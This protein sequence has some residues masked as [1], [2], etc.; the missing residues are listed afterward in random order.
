M[1]DTIVVGAQDFE[2]LKVNKL[3]LRTDIN[4]ETGET[5]EKY[6]YNCKTLNLTIDNGG[7]RL[8]FSL[9]K[10]Y[11]LQDNFYPLGVNSFEVA[12]PSL[13]RSLQD[14]GV[15]ADIDT[16]KVLRLDLFKN[17]ETSKTFNSYADVLRT[18]DLKRTHRREYSEGFLTSNTLR[19]LCFYNKVRELTESLGSNYVKGVYNFNSEN[20]IRGELRFLRHQEVMKNG[21][22]YLKE[23]P[24]KWT[25]LKETY[26]NY[27]SDVFKYELPGGDVELKAEVLKALISFAMNSLREQGR[28]A[29]K[30]FGFYPYSFVNR[31]ELLN[32][33][34]E[35]YSKKQVYNILADIERHK[36]KYG[37]IYKTLEYRRLYSELKEKFINN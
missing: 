7:C 15:I 31:D 10:L 37:E 6:F 18:L 26:S 14:I 9:P 17:V 36:K 33:L 3:I 35:L 16:M 2:I 12:I 11:G 8:Q 23:I 21:I 30:Y 1:I 28:E 29:I 24:N 13:E 22:E 5:L 4:Q 32:T 25:S 27:M 34:K 20:I 19:E